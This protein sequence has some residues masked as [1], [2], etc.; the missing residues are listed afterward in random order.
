MAGR[1]D[2]RLEELGIILPQAQKPKVAK[3]LPYTISGNLLFVSGQIPQWEGEV[4]Y[5]GKVGKNLTLE[6]GREAARLSTLNI[7]AHTRNALAGD[8]DRINRF[9]KVNGFVSVTEDFDEVAAVVNGASELLQEI[10]GDA[11]THA[12]IAIG[13]ANMPIGVAVE[14]EAIIEINSDS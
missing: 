9:L 7:L 5:Q 10:F 3:I 14:I 1:I 13:A 4:R 12:R 8:L 6:E 2:A 11:G